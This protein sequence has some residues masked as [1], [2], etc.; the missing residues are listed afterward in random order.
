MSTGEE[1]QA[2]L[3]SSAVFASEDANGPWYR[4]QISAKLSAI[5]VCPPSQP[6]RT[7]LAHGVKPP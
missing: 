5:S 1:Y 4:T 2:Y 6:H 7:Y 3:R